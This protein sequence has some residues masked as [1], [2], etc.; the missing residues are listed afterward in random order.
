[1]CVCVYM[2]AYHTKPNFML[3]LLNAN[4]ITNG[5]EERPYILIL[6]L[7]SVFSFS[8]WIC[9]K[10]SSLSILF[11]TKKCNLFMEIGKYWNEVYILVIDGKWNPY[12]I[13][14]FAT[15][16]SYWC[17]GVQILHSGSDQSLAHR[18]EQNIIFIIEYSKYSRPVY[19]MQTNIVS[20][21]KLQIWPTHQITC[22]NQY[23]LMWVN[24][25]FYPIN[26]CNSFFDWLESRR[27]NITK[28]Q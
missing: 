2:C 15:K 21:Y 26:F 28:L 1:M 5:D 3:L 7:Q 6:L 4:S 22:L 13:I 27:D 14:G 8:L 12:K 9:I 10:A 18:E 16:V 11:D 17:R 25:L 20:L 23:F 24:K 19:K